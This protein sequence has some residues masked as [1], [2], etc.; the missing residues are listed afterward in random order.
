MSGPLFE[1]KMSVTKNNEFHMKYSFCQAQNSIH[2]RA[3]HMNM[4]QCT[5]EG[6]G[7]GD[8]W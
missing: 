7:Q 4:S 8:V 3:K 1:N 6:Q 2:N 5:G